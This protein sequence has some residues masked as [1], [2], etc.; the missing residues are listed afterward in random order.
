M[1]CSKNKRKYKRRT[2]NR[3]AGQNALTSAVDTRVADAEGAVH[4]GVDDAKDAVD[5]GVADAKSAV[6]TGVAN[7][8][9]ALSDVKNSLSGIFRKVSEGGKRQTRRKR[10]SRQRGGMPSNEMLSGLTTLMNKINLQLP[11]LQ[12]TLTMVNNRAQQTGGK[13]KK[14]LCKGGNSNDVSPK[15]KPE[16]QQ[17]N[18]EKDASFESNPETE[19]K[20]ESNN[21]SQ[22]AKLTEKNQE[23]PSEEQET[24]GGFLEM[25]GFCQTKD[26][27]AEK[28]RMKECIAKCA[29]PQKTE[30]KQ[31]GGKIKKSKKK[32]KKR[33]NKSY[34]KRH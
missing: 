27:K 15:N 10:Q 22:M 33:K 28:Q 26:V 29:P 5:T 13:R 24:C 32:R 31:S 4:T 1:R 21:S 12:G 34:K 25:F 30:E 9:G 18:P 11:K 3:Y 8:K 16:P 17:M 6:D 7:V 2:R 14:F 19:S 23:N 20:S